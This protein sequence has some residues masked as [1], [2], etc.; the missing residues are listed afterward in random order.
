MELDELLKFYPILQDLPPR[1]QHSFYDSG[2]TVHLKGGE[3]I[4]DAIRP[5]RFFFFLT[6]GS[7]RVIYQGQEREIL[8][9]RVQPGETCLL[10]I[11]HLLAGK[12]YQVRASTEQPVTG[13]AIPENLF[14]LFVEGS[15]L[16]CSYLFRSFSERL[17]D[18]LALLEAVS[19]SRLDQ[20]LAGLL[21]TKGV[22]VHTTH[23]QLADELGSVREVISRI[24][25]EFER[26]GLVKLERGKI[27]ILNQ[28]ALVKIAT[29][30]NDSNH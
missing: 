12:S 25:K 16:F 17:V 14:T 29:Y 10:S 22:T 23:S 26:K 1:L 27:K 18:L 6:S 24:L 2:Y 4:F 8:L 13:F 9:Y 28:P 3:T 20:R 19:F 11:C 30:F 5:M 21:L 15:P 7:I